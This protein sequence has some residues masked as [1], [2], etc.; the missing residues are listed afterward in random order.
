MAR[1]KKTEPQATT[2][3]APVVQTLNALIL[4][5]L[6]KAIQPALVFVIPEKL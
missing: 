4:G 2:D 1:Y 5:H 3:D 6:S